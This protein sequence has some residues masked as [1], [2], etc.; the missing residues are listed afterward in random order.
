[1]KVSARLG[2]LGIALPQV[3]A[4]LAAYV[5]AVRSGNLVYTAGQLPI[6]GGRLARTGKV[7]ADVSPEEGKALARIVDVIL[8][9]QR[10]ILTV[11]AHVI[12]CQGIAEATFS[13]PHLVGGDGVLD[14]IP[15]N[16]NAEE[17]ADL[18]RSAEIIASATE[19]LA[20]KL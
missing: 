12:D 2:Q 3:V 9:D 4:P 7:G 16:L 6:D 20:G 13:V 10:S 17:T 18:N 11:C 5:P 8:H 19:S 1:M 15:L 14:C